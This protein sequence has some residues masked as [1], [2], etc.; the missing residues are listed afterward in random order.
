MGHEALSGISVEELLRRARAGDKDALEELFDRC[1]KQL[2]EWAS[3]GGA[4][5]R[6]D[7]ARPSDMVQDTALRAFGAFSSFKGTT[8]AEWLAW[9]QSVFRSRKVQQ[10]R[11]ARRKKRDTLNTVPLEDSEAL[12]MPTPVRSPSQASAFREEWRLLLTHLYELPD[13]QR[14]A[15]SL[16]YL[17]ELPVAEVARHLEKTEPAVAGLL[18]RGVKTLRTRMVEDAGPPPREPSS[19]S[20]LQRDSAVALLDYLRRRDTGE[21]L[22]PVAL[23][24]QYPDC[25]DELRDMLHW[26]DRL[27]ALRPTSSTT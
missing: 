22:E 27:Q 16:C 12:A 6:P 19:E 24:A 8:E 20:A 10:V 21:K 9:L 15:I 14:E 3:Q 26:I 5:A 7:V 23:I 13:D 4:R 1:R 11:H 17:K 25:A 2:G 18:K